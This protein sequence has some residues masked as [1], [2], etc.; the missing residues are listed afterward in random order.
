MKGKCD[1]A[2]EAYIGNMA[3]EQHKILEDWNSKHK[4]KFKI[5]DVVEIIPLYGDDYWGYCVG[6]EPQGKYEIIGVLRIN[7]PY[8]PE[9]HKTPKIYSYKYVIR[10]QN[11]SLEYANM[12]LEIADESDAGLVINLKNP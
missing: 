7:I 6:Y 5:G 8:M 4:P 11:N 3:M 10:R 9:I 1:H 2:A 12:N